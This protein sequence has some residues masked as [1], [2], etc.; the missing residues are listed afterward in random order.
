MT[1]IV[2]DALTGLTSA[3]H[4]KISEN[5]YNIFIENECWLNLYFGKPLQ[6]AFK[7]S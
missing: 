2:P 5:Q 7:N 1:F 4:I 6:N 3:F